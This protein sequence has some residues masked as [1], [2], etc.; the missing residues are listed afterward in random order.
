MSRDPS[1]YLVNYPGMRELWFR[2]NAWTSRSL[3]F[4]KLSIVLAPR[5]HMC[6]HTGVH[7]RKYHISSSF[8]RCLPVLVAHFRYTPC[9]LLTSPL[10]YASLLSLSP[11]FPFRFSS[12]LLP[13][14]L[15]GAHSR[16]DE[17]TNLALKSPGTSITARI[18]SCYLFG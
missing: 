3:I 1:H 2:C 14:I 13:S 5:S 17:R 11:C 12:T 8:P 10:R 6:F 18:N 4:I 9:T 7:F 15:P 16:H